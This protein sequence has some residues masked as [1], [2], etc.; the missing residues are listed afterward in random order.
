MPITPAE[1]VAL[2]RPAMEGLAHAHSQ[3]VAHRDVK[4]ANIHVVADPEG[5]AT[6]KV[7]DFGIAKAVQAGESETQKTTHTSSGFSAFSPAYGAPEQFSSKRFGETGC[8][9]D[10]HALGL[11]LT[12]LV[13]GRR[14]LEGDEFGDLLLAATGETRPTPRARGATV[15][16]GFESVCAKALGLDPKKRYPNAKELLA[17][18][19]A[20]LAADERGQPAAKPR[21]LLPESP[22][23]PEDVDASRLSTET[24]ATSPPAVA[25]ITRARTPARDARTLPRELVGLVLVALIGGGIALTLSARKPPPA[26]VTTTFQS[27]ASVAPAPSIIETASDKPAVTDAVPSASV[28]P[29]AS[30]RSAPATASASP[31]TSRTPLPADQIAALGTPEQKTQLKKQ[32]EEKVYAGRATRHEIGLLI[33][34]CGQLGDTACTAKAVQQQAAQRDDDSR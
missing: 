34:L 15:R 11:I 10:V 30:T 5:H 16:D 22:A 17:A 2:L 13:T 14:A 8:S 25:A 29:L 3:D 4:P 26:P 9:T 6:T 18:L 1:A 31:A 19:D 33:F 7:L 27:P 32:L 12:E 20:A 24:T 21:V 28:R 23:E